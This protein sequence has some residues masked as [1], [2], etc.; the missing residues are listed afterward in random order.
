MDEKL[1]RY[2]PK[3]IQPHITDAYKDDDGYWAVCERGW[4]FA[5]TDCHTAHGNTVAEFKEDILS[6]V[7]V[8][9]EDDWD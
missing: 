6:I 5:N 2:I 9:Y 7:E 3:R 1:M 8:N 4:R